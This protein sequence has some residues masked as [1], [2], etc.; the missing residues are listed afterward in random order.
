M[1]KKAFL[2]CALL[3]FTFFAIP[4]SGS[5]AYEPP[6]EVQTE[7]VLLVNLDTDT[8]VYEKNADERRAPAS[9][10]KITT[11][12]LALEQ[13]ADRLDE[14]TTLNKRIF[15]DLGTG[16]SNAN[17]KEGEE[18]TLRELLYCTMVKSACEGANAVA[19]FVSGGHIDEFVEQMNK[20]VEELGCTNTHYENAHGLDDPNQY[21]T[22]RDI[23]KIVK[24]AM[25]LPYFMEI[26]S[27]AR[28]TMPAT[29]LTPERTLI[30]T[31]LLMDKG[32][33]GE[34]YYSYVKGIKTGYTGDAGRCLVSTASKDGYNYLLIQLGAP[35]EDE[36]GNKLEG[37][38][39]FKEAKQIYEWVLPAF[40]V[41]T[42]VD[43]DKPA[44][45]VKVNLGEEKD[46]VLA[47]PS[48]EMSSLVPS[49]VESS[50]ILLV[51]NLPESV[52]APVKKGDVLGTADLMLSGEK[53]GQ[54]DLVAGESVNRS[55]SLYYM[56]MIDD[57]VNSFW[58]KAV[59]IGIVSLVILY[60]IVS[61]AINIHRKKSDRVRSK[62]RRG[63]KL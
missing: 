38:I 61:I 51:P 24:N 9:L 20:R 15:D 17:L 52:D 39:N 47:Y 21:S 27:T 60:I 33:G 54:V 37:Y 31:N 6:F 29:N 62:S 34:Y 28:Y 3:I 50:S 63:R 55:Q 41:K 35:T 30:T 42:L 23:Y 58:F 44:G 5:A 14:Q 7:S 16:Y 36:N 18:V 8:I 32:V 43:V 19:D 10:T 49:S 59:I 53:I 11:T 56:K 46:T 25:D 57:I 4:I 12:M 45:D 2:L 22:A 13:C 1:K 40:Q 26:C 48:Q